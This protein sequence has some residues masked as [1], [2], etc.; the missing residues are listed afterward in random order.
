MERDIE[1][2]Y[3]ESGVS[4]ETLFLEEYGKNHTLLFTLMKT[5]QKNLMEPTWILLENTRKRNK[6]KCQKNSTEVV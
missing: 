4:Y 2:S 3:R 5:A 1:I 6:Q